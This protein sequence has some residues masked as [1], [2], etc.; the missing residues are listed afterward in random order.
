MR[1]TFFFLLALL[2]GGL[3]GAGCSGPGASQRPCPESQTASCATRV[4]C[5][6]DPARGCDVCICA[7]D[8]MDPDYPSDPFEGNDWDGRDDPWSP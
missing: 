4:V 7:G 1:G 8:E 2:C 3:G 5:E 6:P